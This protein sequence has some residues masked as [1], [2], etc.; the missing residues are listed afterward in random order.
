MMKAIHL[1]SIHCMDERSLNGPK[2]AKKTNDQIGIFL[3]SSSP[4]RYLS[5]VFKIFWMV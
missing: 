1:S 4:Y 2:T 3:K 5:M